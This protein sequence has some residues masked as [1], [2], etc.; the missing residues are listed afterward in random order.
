MDRAGHV[1]VGELRALWA[2]LAERPADMP[3]WVAPRARAAHQELFGTPLAT[4][5][6]LDAENAS[7]ER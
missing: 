6:P 3:S 7:A 1:A 4:M 5:P 2:R